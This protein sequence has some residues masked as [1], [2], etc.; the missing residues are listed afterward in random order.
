MTTL[1][2]YKNSVLTASLTKTKGKIVVKR[3]GYCGEIKTI[4][5]FYLHSK[6]EDGYSSLCKECNDYRAKVER[7]FSEVKI[8]MRKVR[9]YPIRQ[10]NK[11]FPG[12]FRHHLHK[13][14]DGNID[15][16]ICI[17]IPRDIHID[18]S[19]NSVTWRGMDKINAL[20][21]AFLYSQKEKQKKITD[22]NKDYYVR[23]IQSVKTKTCEHCGEKKKVSEFSKNC[24][25]KDG[26]QKWCKEC[27]TVHKKYYDRKVKLINT[28][29]KDDTDTYKIAKIAN[30][31]NYYKVISDGKKHL[32]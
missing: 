32:A 23:F 25:R 8:V 27:T 13:D 18:N 1:N 12:S 14:R 10:L 11:P 30:E 4:N 29:I 2:E 15:D 9:V 5:N 21:W 22:Y 31:M 24:T 28:I 7:G 6:N 20:A 26:L 17:N 16:G 19:H 3:C